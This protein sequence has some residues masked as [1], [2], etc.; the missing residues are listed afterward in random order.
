MQNWYLRIQLLLQAHLSLTAVGLGP[1]DAPWEKPVGVIIGCPDR[2]SVAAHAGSVKTLLSDAD[3]W[4]S[5]QSRSVVELLGEN[6]I[7]ETDVQWRALLS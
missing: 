3:Q 2:H 7:G 6:A 1:T 5:V 4:L